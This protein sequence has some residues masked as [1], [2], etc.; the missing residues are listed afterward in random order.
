M[1]A[2][3]PAPASTSSAP[4]SPADSL[5]PSMPGLLPL[6]PA[7][8][9]A[10]GRLVGGFPSRAE[11]RL[12]LRLWFTTTGSSGLPTC[13]EHEGLDGAERQGVGT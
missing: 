11:D 2:P 12:P 13:S 3:A 9:S 4:E 1:A 5:P 6:G 8:P 7:R 10:G